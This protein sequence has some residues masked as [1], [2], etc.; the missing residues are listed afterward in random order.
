MLRRG[1]VLGLMLALA[2]LPGH[3]THTQRRHQIQQP[4]KICKGNKHQ[5]TVE[6]AHASPV[7][8]EAMAMLTA[9]HKETVRN[10]LSARGCNYHDA[11]YI[12]LFINSILF[13]H[14]IISSRYLH[15]SPA[16]LL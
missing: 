3:M 6:S 13:I 11:N 4:G 14:S 15:G 16:S 12:Q 10:S 2:T 5:K 8:L 9:R 7:S 1:L